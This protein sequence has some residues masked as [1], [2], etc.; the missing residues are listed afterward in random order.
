MAASW[1]ACHA[2]CARRCI[3]IRWSGR[4][5]SHLPSRAAIDLEQANYSYRLFD[6]SFFQMIVGTPEHF[7]AIAVGCFGQRLYAPPLSL[8]KS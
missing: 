1:R 6:S 2:S 7:D 3:T 8:S 4:T 5:R